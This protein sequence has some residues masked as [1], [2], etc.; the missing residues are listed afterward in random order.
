MTDSVESVLRARHLIGV[1]W[2]IVIAV[3]SYKCLD[4]KPFSWRYALILA[5]CF[6]DRVLFGIWQH[7]GG[8]KK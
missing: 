1:A 8:L 5:I 4:I 3:I 2:G 7:L 6:A